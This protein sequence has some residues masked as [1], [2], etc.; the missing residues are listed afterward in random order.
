M[1]DERRYWVRTEQGASWGPYPLPV[2]E[3]MRGRLN[4]RCQI[5]LDGKGWQS[6][7]DFPEL[8]V[9]LAAAAE[10]A[11]K[12]AARPEP[13]APA[14]PEPAQP[15]P[16]P[17]EPEPVGVPGE[18]DLAKFPALR[19][20]ALAAATNASGWL[21][22]HDQDEHFL[23]VSFRR[24][25]PEHVSSDDPE[26]GLFRFL[27]DKKAITPEQ[28]HSAEQQRASAGT[29]VVS[30][31]FQHKL[32]NPADAHRILG[33]HALFL[34]DRALSLWRG[35]FSFELDAPAPPGAYPLGSKWKLLAEASRR[36]DA[37]TIRARLGKKL[38]RR[39]MRSGGNAVGQVDELALNAQETR[40]YAAIDGT[41][42]GDELLM[43]INDSSTGLR[44]LNLLTELGHLSFEAEAEPAKAEE[45]KKAAP[46]PQ[47][48][49]PPAAARPEPPSAAPGPA[50]AARPEPPPAAPRPAPAAR[51]PPP[52]RAAP[53]PAPRP[54]VI[55]APAPAP[56]PAQTPE[57]L[58]ASLRAA[59]T[60]AEKA[61]H[62]A[63]LGLT[64]KATAD[65]VRKSFYTLAR[66]YHP[67]TVADGSDP[68]LRELKGKLFARINEASTVLGDEATR[69]E[70]EAE[71]D[72]A[73]Q[74]DVSRI[75]AAEE[76]FQRGE[77]L[78][79]ARKFTEGLALIEEAIKLNAEEGEFYA[80]RGW[81]KFMLAKERR[82][83]YPEA[84]AECKKA[85]K[86]APMCA[87]A[88]LLQGQM[89]KI[90]GDLKN[91]ETAFKKV[92]DIDGNSVEAARELRYL[93]K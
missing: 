91:A 58:L 17:P 11:A 19:L 18:G 90:L 79:K 49:P 86:L 3:R 1:N 39:V 83:A 33:E 20:Y 71:L 12:A 72:G 51:P 56:R 50:P 31:L 52:K 6:T 59:W 25:T 24:G 23:Q 64:R 54:E 27:V 28:A 78:I 88:W 48:A 40:L 45:P 80:W 57:K 60:R 68:E 14:A 74:V 70:Y 15:A 16:P 81:A 32:I 89:A 65:Q 92:L 13:E 29:D 38:M 87:P 42:S 36:M 75:F 35:R 67:D 5:S 66:D 69:K 53:A 41:R 43:S 62:F 2:L 21:Q 85:V 34:L 44:L 22:L 77:I 26:L 61:D 76:S 4:H 73:A 10:E 55:P 93:H 37:G 46:P 7:A 47:A 82:A 30:A 8:T 63:V 84:L 9:L